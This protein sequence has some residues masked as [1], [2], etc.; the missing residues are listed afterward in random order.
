M[1]FARLNFFLTLQYMVVMLITK[2]M[3]RIGEKSREGSKRTKGSCRAW[4]LKLN[5]SLFE[6]NLKSIAS[7]LTGFTKARVKRKTLLWGGQWL[8]CVSGCVVLL[9]LLSLLPRVRLLMSWKFVWWNNACLFLNWCFLSLLIVFRMDKEKLFKL[10]AEVRIGGK[11]WLFTVPSLPLINR[12]L[13]VVRRR[14]STRPRS[15]TRRS[16]RVFWRRLGRIASQESRRFH[17]PFQAKGLTHCCRPPSFAMMAKSSTSRTLR[18]HRCFQ[19]GFVT[20]CSS[21]V[22]S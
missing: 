8:L 16:F 4:N 11:V 22:H 15:Q 1:I 10:Q 9:A 20:T 5:T 14:L 19:I 6:L 7:L 2:C 13:L 3:F 21:S 18:V 12:E 17:I